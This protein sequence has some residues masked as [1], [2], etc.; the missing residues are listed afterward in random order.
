MR[1]RRPGDALPHLQRAVELGRKD[2]SPLLAE[3]LS[4]LGR[5]EEAEAAFSQAVAALPKDPMALFGRSRVR[6][7]LGRRAEAIADLDA[8]IGLAPGF[9]EAW[10][11][12]GVLK[13]EDKRRGEAAADLRKALELKPALKQTFGS[14]LEDAER[15]E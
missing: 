9:A 3:A 1:T 6:H 15:N 5:T 7:T 11:F 12:R 14:Y 10:G 13:L 2:V 4:Q 8:A